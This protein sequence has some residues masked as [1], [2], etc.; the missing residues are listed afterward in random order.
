MR[1]ATLL[2][3]TAGSIT[4]AVLN[5]LLDHNLV[6]LLQSEW[7]LAVASFLGSMLQPFAPALAG[8]FIAGKIAAPNGFH[9]GFSAV[10]I[11]AVVV[12][13]INTLEV[14]LDNISQKDLMIATQLGFCLGSAVA[15]GLAGMAGATHGRPREA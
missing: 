9:V 7:N 12:I 2:G 14:G 11:G 4:Y 5:I 3:F 15:G 10:F 8:G 1:N 6:M 13:A